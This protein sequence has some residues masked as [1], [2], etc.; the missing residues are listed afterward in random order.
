MTMN[1]DRVNYIVIKND[2]IVIG[3]SNQSIECIKKNKNLKQD[4]GR[5]SYLLLIQSLRIR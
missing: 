4:H 2:L 3:D 1:Y 5:A